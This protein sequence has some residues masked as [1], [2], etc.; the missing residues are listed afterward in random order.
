MDELE[1]VLDQV[2]DWPAALIRLL[3]A[4]FD[5]EPCLV[6]S[7]QAWTNGLLVSTVRLRNVNV[8]KCVETVV[9]QT[10]L[11]VRGNFTSVL[12]KFAVKWE[13]SSTLSPDHQL[14]LYYFDHWVMQWT[15]LVCL[16]LQYLQ[17]PTTIRGYHKPSSTLLV[18][19]GVNKEFTRKGTHH[20]QV[21][22]SKPYFWAIDGLKVLRRITFETLDGEMR[23]SH[24]WQVTVL[25]DLI[26][27]VFRHRGGRPPNGC[28]QPTSSLSVLQWPYTSAEHYPMPVCKKNAVFVVNDRQLYCIGGVTGDRRPT[29]SVERLCLLTGTWTVLANMSR[30]RT[31]HTALFVPRLARILV[32][33]G[34]G[35]FAESEWYDPKL[36]QWTDGPARLERCKRDR[37]LLCGDCIV[38]VD[39]R[40]QHSID[41]IAWPFNQ[42]MWSHFELARSGEHTFV[43]L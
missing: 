41:Y 14:T 38:A 27:F 2:V 5:C 21:L 28:P 8:A 22:D 34:D 33:G 40:R 25:G 39:D 11:L 7:S 29:F 32:L 24:Y 26:L 30:P 23:R 42:W 36:D 12:D 17:F 43:S 18:A 10:P 16:Q 37:L 1:Q 4:Y 35:I 15:L 20:K 13:R 9:E 31:N 3:C 19:G 6:I